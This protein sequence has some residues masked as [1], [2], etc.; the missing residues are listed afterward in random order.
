VAATN[1]YA[2]RQRDDFEIF[3][4]SRPWYDTT[5][6]E[7]YRFLGCLVYIGMHPES[8]RD[9]YWSRTHRLERYISLRRF[10]QLHRYFTIRDKGIH[11][12]QPDK[13]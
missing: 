1:S 8:K 4:S 5:S 12:K 7:I 13:E 2:Q 11:L 3:F 6:A 9:D 10:K